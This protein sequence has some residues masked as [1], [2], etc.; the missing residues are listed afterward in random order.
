MQCTQSYCVMFEV[1]GR[2]RI[3]VPCMELIRFYFGSSSSLI[4]KL[5]LPPLE[6]ES[7]FTNASLDAKSGR[8]RI[9][10]A[11]KISGASAADIGRISMDPMTWRAAQ[12]IGASCLKASTSQQAIHPQ[13][14]FPFE[15]KTNLVASGKWLS[16]GDQLKATFL[17]YSL[18]SCSHPF[19]FKS[20]RYKMKD[21]QPPRKGPQ[22]SLEC[23]DARPQRGRHT[24]MDSSGQSLIDQD[25]SNDL[26]PKLKTFKTEPRF[27]DLKY[28][29]IW[30]TKT[31]SVAPNSTSFQTSQRPVDFVAVGEAGSERRVRPVDLAL[32]TTTNALNVDVI[33]DFLREVVADMQ[34]IKDIEI[35][36][37]TESQYDGWSVPISLLADEDG[38]IDPRLM[39]ADIYEVSRMRRASV[40]AFKR[41]SE[42]LCA[43]AIESS[44]THVK[45]YPTTGKDAEEVWETLR[46]ASVDFLRGARSDLKTTSLSK[47]IHWAFG[48][49]LVR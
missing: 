48:V 2:H 41:N 23:S 7:L 42:H 37:L 8:L 27:P 43:V 14:L 49:Y 5:F 47:L 13:A 22:Q 24:A 15:G 44:P 26:A 21:T 29:S 18:R 19:P 39:M 31:L 25:P 36:L 3:I 28:K 17:V 33:P 11:E 40:F 16:L 46:C 32:V 20:M 6:K 4:S 30:K 45:V 10:L 12:H 34:S 35:E 38:E 9:E 1:L